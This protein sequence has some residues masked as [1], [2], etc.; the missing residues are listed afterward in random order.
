M[1]KKLQAGVE[2]QV[3]GYE[4]KLIDKEED[5]KQVYQFRL[6]LLCLFLIED[7]AK[8]GDEELFTKMHYVQIRNRQ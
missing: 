1:L 8:D 2:S 4:K 3:S 5:M 6:V 7:Y